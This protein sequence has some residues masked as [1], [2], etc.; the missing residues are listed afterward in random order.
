MISMHSGT[1]TTTQDPKNPEHVKTFTFDL[2]Y[3]SHNGFQRDKD[4]VLISADP[5]HKFAGQVSCFKT[6]LQCQ[7]F[8]VLFLMMCSQCESTIILCKHKYMLPYENFTLN[9][10]LFY[11]EREVQKYSYCLSNF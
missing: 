6:Q 11:A 9:L 3:W 1:T 2:A 10:L 7:F 4:G 8:V 5:S